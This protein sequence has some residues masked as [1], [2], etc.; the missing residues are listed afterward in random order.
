MNLDR[1]TRIPF[2]EKGRDYSGCDCW[3]IPYLIYRDLLHIELP[4]YVDSYQNTA[5]VRE[6]SRLMDKERVT[7]VQV[8]KPEPYDIVNIRLRNRPLHC[9][10]CIGEGRFI[11]CLDGTNTTVERLD[12][13]AWRHRI[14]GYYRY[15]R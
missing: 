9:G 15:T 11:H 13:L 12:A 10:V 3:G 2:K 7:W 4:L 5:D 1:Y 8:D 14:V 6:I